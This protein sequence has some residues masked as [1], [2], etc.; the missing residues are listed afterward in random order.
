VPPAV[1]PTLARGWRTPPAPDLLLRRK[2]PRPLL[3]GKSAWGARSA[4][5][6]NTNLSA[7]AWRWLSR[8]WLRS[9]QRCGSC[10]YGSIPRQD[11]HGDCHQ[12]RCLCARPKLNRRTAALSSLLRPHR[13]FGIHRC[14]PARRPGRPR[15][16]RPWPKFTSPSSTVFHSSSAPALRHSRQHN[17]RVW[18]AGIAWALPVALEL[19]VDLLR[20]RASLTQALTR[21]ASATEDPGQRLGAPGPAEA[22]GQPSPV[23]S[24]SAEPVGRHGT[25]RVAVGGRSP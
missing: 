1:R 4:V 20:P 25:G 11:A 24:S 21:V 8:Q 5:S 12:S 10:R 16:L 3:L 13:T 7:R 9:L 19:S 23:R 17:W 14:G 6:T 22:A 15:R 18:Q 2:G